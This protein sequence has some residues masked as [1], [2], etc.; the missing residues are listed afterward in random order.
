V[1]EPAASPGARLYAL[2]A[3]LILIWGINWPVIK[4][5]LDY[6]TPLW[7]AAARFALGIVSMVVFLAAFGRL[8]LPPR[9]DWPIVLSVGVLQLALFLGLVNMGLLHVEAGRTAVLAYTTPLWVTPGA[10]LLLRERLSV[11]KLLG[12]AL[13]FAGLAV[14]FNPL[15][16]DWRDREVVLGNGLVLLAAVAWAAAILHVRG[17]RWRST[18]LDLITWQMILACVLLVPAAYLLE[19][20]PAPNWTPELGA[21]LLFNGPIATAFCFWASVTVTRSLPAVTTS[22]SFLGVPVTGVI[23]SAL[24]LR[25]PLTASLIG[26]LA[27]ILAGIV[28]VNL[29]RR[30]ERV[31]P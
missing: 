31:T 13:G 25:E 28:L 12:V 15:Q 2:F 9:S 26:G 21:V 14:L 10:A 6:I 18:A 24:W 3:V 30:R 5:G 16:F 27:L 19:G 1:T 22:L 11:Q 20:L 7:F 4:V 8:R 29:S 23:A 17:H